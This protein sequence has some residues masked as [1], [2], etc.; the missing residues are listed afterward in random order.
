MD[1]LK[2]MDFKHKPYPVTY[3]ALQPFSSE[4]ILTILTGIQ[5]CSEVS[6][7]MSITNPFS[8]QFHNTKPLLPSTQDI[9]LDITA[10][11]FTGFFR[12]S[13][14]TFDKEALMLQI[15][16]IKILYT[17]QQ[18]QMVENITKKQSNCK[19]WHRFRTGRITA[20]VFKTVCRTSILS[21]AMSLIKR[22]CYPEY[23]KFSCAAINYGKDNEAIARKYYGE[24]MA[25]KHKSFKVEECGLYINNKFPHLGASPD[26]IISCDCC[27]VG[28]VEIKCPYSA[29]NDANLSAYIEKKTSPL[30]TVQIGGNESATIC[31]S[32]EYYYQLQMQMQ[33]TETFFGDLV[34]WHTEELVIIRVQ[35]DD[36]FWAREYPKT[37]SFFYEILMPELLGK[38]YTR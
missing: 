28:V 2:N 15:N 32:H 34:V 33:L 1:K 17:D 19:E 12:S 24:Y 3:K 8:E 16:D 20:S 35:R 25:E 31:Y 27:G 38:F 7:I 36:D 30:Q 14:L 22:I 4:D 11:L 10:I 18:V 37:L 23:N 5:K 26:G 29:R 9:P 13:F 6:A 21:P